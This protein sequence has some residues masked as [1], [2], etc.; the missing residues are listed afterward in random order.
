MR[1]LNCREIQMAAPDEGAQAVQKA[2]ACRQIAR[3]GPRLYVGRAFPCAPKAFVISL[4]RVHRQADRGHGRVRAQAQ[5]GAKDVAM[6]GQ[7]RQK[8]AHLAGHAD[9][10]GAGIMVFVG[11]E[12]IFV[13]QADQVDI[14][15]IIQLARAHLAHGQHHHARAGGGIIL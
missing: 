7:V 1:I 4:G 6:R 8:A 12:R 3:A 10:R 2:R 15:G 5:I 11:R 14:R 13:E 9:E